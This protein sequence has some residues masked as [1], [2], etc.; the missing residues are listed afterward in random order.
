MLKKEIIS[1][2]IKKLVCD[3]LKSIFDKNAYFLVQFCVTKMV[4][5]KSEES[6]SYLLKNG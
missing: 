3:V 2:L 6:T 4:N 1:Y 5:I